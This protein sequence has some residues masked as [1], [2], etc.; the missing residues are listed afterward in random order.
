MRLG[1]LCS[2]PRMRRHHLKKPSNKPKRLIVRPLLNV[3]MKAFLSI[4]FL[5]FA[6]QISIAEPTNKQLIGHWSY[7][8][9]HL[10]SEYTFRE[11]GTFTGQVT[12]DTK[13]IWTFAGKWSLTGDTLNYEYTKS[14]L[15]RIPVGTTDHDKLLE[16][17]KDHYIIEARDSSKRKYSKTS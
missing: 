16:V 12:Q 15:E 5:C 13:V 4:I 17:T 6:S 9:E 7:A 8:D 10:I 1:D 11:D 2:N 3:S 14:S